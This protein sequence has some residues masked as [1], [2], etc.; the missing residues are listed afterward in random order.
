MVDN[1]YTPVF[2]KQIGDPTT[3]RDAFICTMESGAMGLD[4][5]TL[6]KT[7][8]WGGQLE[9]HQTDHVG[10]TD[11]YD[12]A[13][14]WKY[15]GAVL[16][17]GTGGWAGVKAAL[18]QGRA[19]MLQGDY[20]QIP[21]TYKCQKDFNDG[22][23]ICLIPDAFIW[24]RTGDPLCSAFKNVP[25]DT[26]R[27]YAEKLNP[28]VQFA[29]SASHPVQAVVHRFH[30]DTGV[31]KLYLA[32]TVV[33]GGVTKIASWSTVPWSGIA[34][35]APCR[36]EQILPGTVHG[37]ATVAYIIDGASSI[38]GRY[39]HTGEAYGTYVL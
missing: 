33:V 25:E 38:K 27:A 13:T 9:Q 20:D 35:S 28:H 8:V 2:R 1:Y 4:Y 12:L 11:L 16:T 17:Q 19:V 5:H 10:G 29:F 31:R 30:I 21:Y 24:A 34:S 22:H 3:T 23:C 26:I 15:Y 36:A 7:Q 37:G 14:A 6:G 32:N 18:A 39:L